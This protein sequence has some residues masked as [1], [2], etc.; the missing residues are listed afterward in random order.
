M[1]IYVCN[2]IINFI[3]NCKKGDYVD[4]KLWELERERALEMLKYEVEM[5]KVRNKI[6]QR[7]QYLNQKGDK[8]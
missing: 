3:E 1:R 4:K 5:S 7:K 6:G 2:M 8:T